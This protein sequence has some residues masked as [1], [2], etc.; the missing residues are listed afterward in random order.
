MVIVKTPA[1][2]EPVGLRTSVDA[3]TF[4][5]KKLN[6]KKPNPTATPTLRRREV[7]SKTQNA[8]QINSKHVACNTLV[9]LLP[10]LTESF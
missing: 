6:K 9:E 3:L 5:K 4:Q 2:P 1:A 8:K 7:F 10:H